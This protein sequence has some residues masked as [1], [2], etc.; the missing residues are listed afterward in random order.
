M[1]IDQWL[2]DSW[3]VLAR[4]VV[5][6]CLGYVALIVFLRI[7]GK[8][9]LARMNAFD[10]VVTVSLGSTLASVLVSKDVALAQ[11][12][13]ALALLIG[14]QFLITWSS[15]RVRRVRSFVTGEPTLLLRDGRFADRAMRAARVNR[16]DVYAAIRSSGIPD[17][18]RVGAVV[19]E[20]DGSF[21]VIAA[22]DGMPSRIVGLERADG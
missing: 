3:S 15:V 8:R 4:T 7:A 13:L 6:G 17:I 1:P 14:L 12:A 11:G 20:T 18:G 16:D 5:V 22:A 9:T 19:L 2:F 21:S 10:M